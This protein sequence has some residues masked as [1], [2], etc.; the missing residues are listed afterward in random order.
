MIKDFSAITDFILNS[1]KECKSINPNVKCVEPDYCYISYLD[2][3]Y[4]AKDISIRYAQAVS[5]IGVENETIK[6][7]QL[8]TLD[9]VC[10]YHKGHY[11]KL[12]DAYGFVMKW[13]ESN[14]YEIIEKV[15]ERYIDGIWNK[16]NAEEWLTERQVPIRKNKSYKKFC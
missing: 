15:R 13:I 4:K 14:G 1:T 6:F 9:T 12:S 16:E 7:E 5:E 2:G 11:E 10:V 3:E 8:K